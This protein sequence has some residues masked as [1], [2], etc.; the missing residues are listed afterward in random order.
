MGDSKSPCEGGRRWDPE[1]IKAIGGMSYVQME[2][3]SSSV[4]DAT[5]SGR[6]GCQSK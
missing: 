1:H 5:A 3:T 4:T 2:G 6:D